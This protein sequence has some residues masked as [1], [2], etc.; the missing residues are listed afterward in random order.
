MLNQKR[1]DAHKEMDKPYK[2]FADQVKE[3][4][5]IVNTAV[6][7]VRAQEKELEESER[8]E[9]KEILSGMFDKRLE[10]YTDFPLQFDDFLNAQP[11]VLNKSITLNNGEEIL[12]HWFEIKNKDIQVIQNLPDADKVMTKYVLNPDSLTEVLSQVQVERKAEERAKRVS[13]PTDAV[14]F[15][16]YVEPEDETISTFVVYGTD[17]TNRVIE[18]MNLNKIN[19]KKL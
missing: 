19:Y 17:E 2:E 14:D 13:K 10:I 11:N 12:A 9:K 6:T 7:T 18:F 3:I 5:D 8:T 1:I 4:S 16:N 15:D